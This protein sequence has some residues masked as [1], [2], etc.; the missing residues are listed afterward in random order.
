MRRALVVTLALLWGCA[1]EFK[2]ESNVDGLRV[3]GVR[4]EP[5]EL[6][7]GETAQLE[8]LVVDPS[9]PG[10]QNAIFW[11][12]CD[13]DP[14]DLGR[15]ACSD[16]AQFGD[17]ASL[18]QPG[19]GG[20]GGTPAL[21]PGMKLAGFG[22]RAFYSAPADLFAQ[23]DPGDSR[24]QTGTVAQLLLF[25]IGEPISPTATEEELS[26]VLA[27]VRSGETPSVIAI[28]RVRVS[29]AEMVNRNP[30]IGDLMLDGRAIPEGAHVFF[31]PGDESALEFTAPEHAFEQ[32][33]QVVPG[34][35]ETR[36]E[37]LIAAPYTTGGSFSLERVAV[38]EP[39]TTVFRAPGGR[40][41]D[42]VPAP[43]RG[44][45]WVVY[46][47][48]RGGQAWREHRLHACEPTMEAPR[49]VRVT[50]EAAAGGVRVALQGEGVDRVL[51]AF[52]GGVALRDAAYSPSA[53][54]FRGM[55]PEGALPA[56][57]HAVTLRTRDCVD[58][59]TGHQVQVQ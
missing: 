49:V 25:V 38:N 23:L 43:G 40:E 26:Q 54:R 27:R 50:T 24:R 19:A 11:L 48:T 53:G 2:P 14:F 7:P 21:P 34:G 42:P 44:R 15:S 46:R 59:E 6:R 51:D 3:L 8:A 52:V 4:A 30:E 56:G 58:Y 17:P 41:D 20:D 10:R 28:F 31:R 35:V 47:D 39:V 12:S 36:T 22:D 32:Y 16:L 18:V 37:R 55:L 45:F 33:E 57:A 13:P 1:E 5:A 29:E 9:A